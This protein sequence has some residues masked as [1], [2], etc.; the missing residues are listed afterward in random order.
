MRRKSVDKLIVDLQ[1]RE[2]ELNC[3]YEVEE[4][5]S[6]A[7]LPLEEALRKIVAKLPAGWQYPD[8]C[9]AKIRYGDFEVQTKGFRNSPWVQNADIL[10]QEE[11]VGRVTVCYTEEKP[12]ADEGPFLKEERRLIDT[13]ADRLKHRI[14][15]INLK[16]IFEKQELKGKRQGELDNAIGIAAEPLL[17]Q[18]EAK[19][20]YSSGRSKKAGANI[21][22][23]WRMQSVEHIAELMDPNRFG[24]KAMYLFGSTQ[25]ATA[26]PQSDI[27][28]L[29]HFIGTQKQEKDLLSWLEGWSLCLSYMNYLKTGYKTD[30]LLSIHIITDE[31]I[32]NRTSYAVKIGATDEPALL[33]PLGKGSSPTTN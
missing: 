2:K 33:I 18:A 11:I 26:G 25:N 7:S 9:Q 31:D 14:L 19:S 15:H 8:A 32:R 22:W 3:L 27:D 20:G 5:M 17:V 30:G 12:L 16:T 4:T 6:E 21:H 28:L 29:I 1:E 23:R 13:I 24:V 10:V